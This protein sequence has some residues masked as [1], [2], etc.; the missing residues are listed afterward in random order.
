MTRFDLAEATDLLRRAPDT[1]R[2]LV[3]SLPESWLYANEGEGS[4]SPH[5]I[6][7]HLVHGEETDWIAR[8]RIILE[9]GETRAFDPFDREAMF[10]KYADWSIDDL[11]DRF[12]ALRRAN[13]EALAA[14]D[15][16]PDDLTTTGT[17]PTFGRVTL[18]QLLATWAVHDLAHLAQIARVAAKQYGDAVGPWREYLPILTR[19]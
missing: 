17:H 7:G 9:R 10:R 14:L 18:E 11:L 19:R 16:G 13:L 2:A 5:A 6:V 4:W 12:A 1:L 15:L 8:T 3:T